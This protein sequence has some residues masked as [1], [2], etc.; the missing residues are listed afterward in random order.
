MYTNTITQTQIYK[1]TNKNTN[2][3]TQ[4]A[5][6]TPSLPPTDLYLTA[7]E[8][9]ASSACAIVTLTGCCTITTGGSYQEEHPGTLYYGFLS[10]NYH[11]L[12][13]PGRRQCIYQQ[14]IATWMIAQQ[15]SSFHALEKPGHIHLFSLWLDPVHCAGL[16]RI[17]DRNIKTYIIYSYIY[18]V[19]LTHRIIEIILPIRI[20]PLFCKTFNFSSFPLFSLSYQPENL[21]TCGF[22]SWSYQYSRFQWG[23][24]SQL[25]VYQVFSHR[26][27]SALLIQQGWISKGD[28]VKSWEFIKS[29]SPQA[30]ISRA[31]CVHMS[32]GL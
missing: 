10:R 9:L 27:L 22:L 3:E 15:F 28:R 20:L 17:C 26:P 2:E 24:S 13:Y 12:P 32:Y 23:L 4:P 14:L 29:F 1:F 30:S 18:T 6:A 8:C 31:K 7:G 25:R 11:Q 21:R 16:E 5:L 19:M